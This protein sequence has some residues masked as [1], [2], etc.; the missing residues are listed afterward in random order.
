[1]PLV[2]LKMFQKYSVLGILDHA[3]QQKYATNYIAAAHNNIGSR[4]ISQRNKPDQVL[5]HD[6]TMAKPATLFSTTTPIRVTLSL[7]SLSLFQ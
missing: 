5:I 1:M 7:L 3:V 4:V 6:G 2:I